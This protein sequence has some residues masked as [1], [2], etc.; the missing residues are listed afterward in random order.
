MDGNHKLCRLR[1]LSKL[2]F[3]T[4]KTYLPQVKES[5]ILRRSKRIAVKNKHIK[6]I[7]NKIKHNL[8]KHAK[9]TK[10]NRYNTIK[11]NKLKSNK[12]RQIKSCKKDLIIKFDN[13][14]DG[15]PIP[16]SY[17]CKNHNS[18]RS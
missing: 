3:K 6:K 16:G 10:Q 4:K 12:N 13:G 5:P 17:Y 9:Q 11:T 18:K 7:T 2:S 14:C 8:K 15:T 1:C